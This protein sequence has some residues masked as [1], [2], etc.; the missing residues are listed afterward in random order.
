MTLAD[1][2]QLRGGTVDY[3]HETKDM[4]SKLGLVNSAAVLHPAG[5]VMLSRTAS[6]GFSGIMARDMATS[7]DFATW[8]CGERLH[9]KYLLYVLRAMAPDLRRVAAGSTHKTIYMPDIEELRMPAPSMEEQRRIAD[10]LDAATSSIDRLSSLTA[11]QLSAIEERGIEFARVMTTGTGEPDSRRTGVSWMPHM[12]KDWRLHRVGRVFRTGSGT[13]PTSSNADY[14]GDGSPWVNTGDLRDG[15]VVDVKR[16]VTQLALRDFSA[17]KTYAP[18]SLVVAMYGATI[19][20][21]GILGMRACVN[22]ACCVLAESP[23]IDSKYAFYWFLSQRQEII[24]LASGGGQP[25]ISQ[26]VI[27]SLRIPAPRIREQRHIV[28]AIDT[29]RENQSSMCAALTRRL[30]LLAE[31]RQ[32]LI[33]ATVTGQIDVTAARGVG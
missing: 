1:V 33:T 14:F 8:T 12:H 9:P 21:L 27:R 20:R 32:A 13:T 5:T 15:P 4:I 31:R 3:V 26:D 7:Q 30:S 18:G 23:V 24:G 28:A 10:F 25:N 29:E 6:V 11:R 16:S 19:G 2:W 17:L 22:Q